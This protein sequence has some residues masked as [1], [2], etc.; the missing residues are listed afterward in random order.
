M[1]QPPDGGA[2]IHPHNHEQHIPHFRPLVLTDSAPHPPPLSKIVFKSSWEVLINRWNNKGG[3]CR[4]GGHKNS[5]F[6]V[7]IFNGFYLMTDF[8]Q[9]QAA[10]HPIWSHTH[11][12]ATIVNK[13]VARSGHLIVVANYEEG[14]NNGVCIYN[15][16]YHKDVFRHTIWTQYTPLQTKYKQDDR[17]VFH[18]IIKRGR[19][20]FNIYSNY[21]LV[22][23]SSHSPDMCIPV[24]N[25]ECKTWQ[26]DHQRRGGRRGKQDRAQTVWKPCQRASSR[27][28][29]KIFL[30]D[31]AF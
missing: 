16:F 18:V 11:I 3:L 23:N 10:P 14:I 26:Q 7:C 24:T 27:C 12:A 21:I 6:H 15:H 22:I 31:A 29:H 9:R 2:I 17:S 28:R 20:N 8:I 25:R 13:I 4:S 5:F 30:G 1:Q 19:G